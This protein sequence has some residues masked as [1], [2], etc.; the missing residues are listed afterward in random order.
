MH[1]III[2]QSKYGA[3]RQYAGWIGKALQIPAVEADKV[4][5]TQL[6]AA[7]FLILGTSIYIGKMLLRSWLQQHE[8]QLAGR[9]LFL[10]VVCATNPEEKEKLNSYVAQNVPAS[11]LTHCQR[12]FFP[13]KIRFSQLSLADKLK[14]RAGSLMAR[15][16]GKQLDASDFDRLDESNTTPLLTD[17]RQ[18]YQHQS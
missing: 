1:G 8:S 12:Y 17:V 18:F 13:G 6:A 10:F 9:P 4:T 3:T 11:L 15:L 14:V 7:D 16:T 2:F 5:P